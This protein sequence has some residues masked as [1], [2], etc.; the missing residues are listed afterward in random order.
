MVVEAEVLSGAEVAIAHCGRLFTQGEV[1]AIIDLAGRWPALSRSGLAARVCEQLQWQRASGG[2]KTREC[3]DLLSKLEQR[4]ALR[5]P[6]LRG[7]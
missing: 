2:L 1:D 7:G 4:G 6:A 3:L 5:L